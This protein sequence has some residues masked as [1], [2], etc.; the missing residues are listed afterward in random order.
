MEKLRYTFTLP[1]HMLSDFVA[2][3]ILSERPFAHS[4]ALDLVHTK[5]TPYHKFL[6]II[7]LEL[8]FLPCFH[9]EYETSLTH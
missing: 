8:S 7:N 1:V 4:V 9:V 6:H 2:V 5:T 3:Q